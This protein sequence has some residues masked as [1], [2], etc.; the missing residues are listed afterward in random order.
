MADRRYL[1]QRVIALIE[2]GFSA[3][4]AGW[5]CQLSLRIAQR[6]VHKFKNYGE[7]QRRY[8]TGP[9]P[10]STREEDEAVRRV[11]EE[12]SFCSV[13]HIRAVAN[14]PG[15][16]WTVMNC[17][18]DANIHCWRATSKEGLI[19][20]QAVDRL[21][22]ATGWWDFDWGSVIFS[23]ETS[24]SSDCESRGHVYREPGT[25]YDTRYVQWHERFS[26]SCW[27]WMSHAGVGMLERIHSRFNAPQYRHIFENVMLHSVRVRNLKVNL[28]FQQDNHPVRCS[29]GIQRWFAWRPEIELIP[30]PPK[31]TDLKHCRAYVG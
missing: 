7:F 31:S 18:R 16:F 24:I 22:F 17:L 29:M 23:D 27:G 15:I 19:D 28:I 10:C 12:N 2:N 14:F 13:N 4:E 5:R 6:W 30:W 21:A 25:R 11:V 3:S 1:R 9:P 20:E 26:L 8:S